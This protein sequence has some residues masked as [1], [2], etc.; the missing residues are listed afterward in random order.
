MTSNKYNTR[1]SYMPQMC[2]A[3]E[4]TNKCSFI[5]I[6]PCTGAHKDVRYSR[7]AM[8]WS[9]HRCYNIMIILGILILPCTTGAQK[10]IRY[11]YHV[12]HWSTQRYQAFSSRHAMGY[13]IISVILFMPCI[14]TYIG[15]RHSHHTKHWSTQ[16]YQAFSS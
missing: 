11:S 1:G 15:I 7:H 5:L 3:L 4:I 8:H 12:M 14:R 6:M 16:N 10:Y 2:N 9:A 13:T